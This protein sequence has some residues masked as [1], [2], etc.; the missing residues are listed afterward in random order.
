MVVLVSGCSSHGIV[1]DMP[2]CS[3]QQFTLHENDIRIKKR[4]DLIQPL[5]SLEYPACFKYA[6]PNTSQVVVDVGWF[7]FIHVGTGPDKELPASQLGIH[8][9]FPNSFNQPS[10]VNELIDSEMSRTDRENKTN[11]RID[12]HTLS[13]IEAQCVKYDFMYNLNQKTSNYPT[14]SGTIKFVVFEYKASVWS[15][16]LEWNSKQPEPPEIDQYF[17]HA[18]ATFKFLDQAPAN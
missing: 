15:I 7:L 13:G 16:W 3:Y 5:F 6:D 12:T 18:L 1:E 8:Q 14:Y 2:D 4:P 17:E 11:F 9:T 10:T